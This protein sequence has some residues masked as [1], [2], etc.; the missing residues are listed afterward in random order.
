MAGR[1]PQSFIDELL[2]RTDIVEVI[3]SRIGLR[4]SGRNHSALCPFHDEKSPSFSVNPDKQF[5]YCFGCGAGGNALGFIMEYDH[6]EF[7]AAVEELAKR[8]GMQVPE[9]SPRNPE[10]EKKRK[11]LYDQLEKTQQF[12]CEQLRQHP[13]K[14]VA[15]KY[16]KGREINGQIA[17]EF[18]IG[19]APPGWDNLIRA[20]ATT[21]A[22]KE[23]LIEAGM[24]ISKPDENKCYDRFRDR[25]MFPIRDSRGRTIAF[26]GRVLGDDKPK[27]LNSPESPIFHKS[28]QLYGVYEARKKSNRL[29]R[30]VIVEGYMDV[31]ALAQHNI[32]NAVATLGT[33]TSSA[34]LAN[35]FRMVPEIVFCFDGDK[36]GLKAAERALETSLPELQDGRQIRFLFLPEGEDPDT[37]VRKEGREAFN[38][39]ITNAMSLPDYFFESLTKQVDMATLDGKARLSSLALPFIQQLPKGI[40]HQLML[41]RLSELTGVS[42]ERLIQLS[43]STRPA[44]SPNNNRYDEQPP[45]YFSESIDTS[46]NRK[47]RHEN[48]PRQKNHSVASFAQH[49]I[50]LLLQEPTIA[51][52]IELPEELRQNKDTD[53]ELLLEVITTL[54]KQPNLKTALLISH[55]D[56]KESQE[57]LIGLASKE[58]LLANTEGIQRELE[59]TLKKLAVQ[60]DNRTEKSFELL[61]IKIQNQTAS[62]SDILKFTQLSQQQTEDENKP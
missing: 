7:P 10:F 5:Y 26:G 38:T 13:K 35:L 16:L 19:Y 46:H 61:K 27:Y 17:K 4:K 52:C 12:Y 60:I 18:G 59:D 39:R 11:S 44:S 21:P 8:A 37:L 15:V 29:T 40:L 45:E 47:A 36:A 33:A 42:T 1:I 3:D 41:D 25:I 50:T 55:W 22:D 9:E 51:N 56:D 62:K 58:R 48:K 14:S 32:T 30:F 49:A 54:E 31:V 34:H 53:T 43:R 6:L 57:K 20:L 23:Q 24:L 28:N 2:D